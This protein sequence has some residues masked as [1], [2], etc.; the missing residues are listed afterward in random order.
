MITRYSFLAGSMLAA[1]LMG[2][3]TAALAGSPDAVLTG[4]VKSA[5]EGPMEG[6]VVSAR[7]DG[8]TYTISVVSDERGRYRFPAGRLEAGHYSLAIRAVGYDLRAP[9]DATLTPGKSAAADLDL[10]KTKALGA[11]LSGAEWLLSVPGT[12]DQKGLLNMCQE[13]HT[14]ERVLE[15]THDAAELKP[16]M[17]R[18][19]NYAYNS[20]PLHPQL[21]KVPRYPRAYDVRLIPSSCNCSGMASQ[22]QLEHNLRLAIFVE[23][24]AASDR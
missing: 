21:R 8:A 14:L 20:W 15:S 1:S 19:G 9:S 4:V 12:E 24:A 22:H 2:A 3:A 11:Q 6:V 7:R 16:L 17:L 5:E 18:M 23:K 10:I 13:C